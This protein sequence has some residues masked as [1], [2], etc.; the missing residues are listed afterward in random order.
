LSGD[1]EVAAAP[2]SRKARLWNITA[3]QCQL[4]SNKLTQDR[5][6]GMSQMGHERALPAL[7]DTEKLL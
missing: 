3:R 6:I 5:G 7:L 2:N 1:V 4:L